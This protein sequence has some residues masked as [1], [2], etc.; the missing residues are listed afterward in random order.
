MK[1]RFISHSFAP[2]FVLKEALDLFEALPSKIN[3][4]VSFF[5]SR[6]HQ[7]G[8]FI[9]G[10]GALTFW[11]ISPENMQKE[12]EKLAGLFPLSRSAKIESDDFF[13][14]EDQ[15][16]KAKA[17]FNQMVIDELTMERA[18]LVAMTLA[19]SVVMSYFEE[20]VS[21]IFENVNAMIRR[22]ST[23]PARLRVSLRPFYQLISSAILKRNAVAGVL[24]LLDRP[25][26]L[27]TDLTVDAIYNDIRASFDLNE[28]L[29]ALEYK[30]NA[31]QSSMDFMLDVA[32]D[33]RIFVLEVAIVVLIAF[34]VVWNVF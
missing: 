11:N 19:Q 16:Q 14:L 21:E 3:P 33:H 20:S 17:D 29:Q 15:G 7:S 23:R 31:M 34:E 1:H 9:H 24:H 18:E 25:E 6:G 32:R 8:I 22:E 28:R 4:K 2:D 5:A 30:L 26:L 10:F 27:W 13:V 12:I